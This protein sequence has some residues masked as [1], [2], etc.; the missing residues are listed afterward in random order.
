MAHLSVYFYKI[1]TTMRVPNV[2][3]ASIM[4]ISFSILYE[5]TQPEYGSEKGTLD[6]F[7]LGT[8]FVSKFIQPVFTPSKTTNLRNEI[9]RFRIGSGTL[10]GMDEC[11]ALA[12]LGARINLIHFHRFEPVPRSPFNSREVL[13][14]R[15]VVRRLMCTRRELNLRMEVK[16]HLTIWIEFVLLAIT[17]KRRQT[18]A[19]IDMACEDTLMKFCDFLLLEEADSFLGLADDPDCP[20]YNPFYYDPEGDILLLEA[21]LNSAKVHSVLSLGNFLTSGYQPGILYPQDSYEEGT[22]H[23]QSNIKEEWFSGY[24]NIPLAPVIKKME[25]FLQ[26]CHTGKFAYRE[27]LSAIN[28]PGTFQRCMLA[29]FLDMLCMVDGSLYGRLLVEH[30][31]WSK[32][33]CHRA[34]DFYRKGLRLKSLIDV[35]AKLPHPPRQR[36]LHLHEQ[37]HCALRTIRPSVSLCKKGCQGQS[38]L[39]WDCPDCEDSQFCH[40]SR[41]SHPQLHL[42][43]RYPNLID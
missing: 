3:I 6:L 16:H 17:L 38:L 32:W 12:D 8:I 33:A 42:G 40:S 26:T 34:I 24:F 7:K 21:I 18:D 39:R 22:M 41:V 23:K 14:I 31:L 25:F 2:P 19:S 20:A 4:L 9:T 5:G 10:P 15:P 37:K 27:C 1:T 28:A 36:S 29:F 43:I 11:L 30:A 13:L 35:I